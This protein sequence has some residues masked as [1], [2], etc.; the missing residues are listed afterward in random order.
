MLFAIPPIPK[1]TKFNINN[2][3]TINVAKNISFSKE[4]I[5]SIYGFKF[6]NAAKQT[7]SW[8]TKNKDIDPLSRVNIKVVMAYPRLAN[9]QR[10]LTKKI[11]YII[12][13]P[14]L[15]ARENILK[16]AQ[17]IPFIVLP[18]WHGTH[19]MSRVLKKLA[20]LYLKIV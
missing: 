2:T 9:K 7:A 12:M 3:N 1:H 14:D 18:F 5:N 20:K 6:K 8:L 11:P 4:F 13:R 15:K 19:N 17:K 10:D 16:N